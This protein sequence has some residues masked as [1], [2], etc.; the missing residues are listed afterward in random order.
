[1]RRVVFSNSSR[2]VMTGCKRYYY[3]YN[4]LNLRPEVE[5]TNFRVGGVWH[6]IKQRFYEGYRSYDWLYKDGVIKIIPGRETCG[7]EI[8]PRLERISKEVLR[9]KT[10][11][12][13]DSVRELW[14]DKERPLLE[15]MAGTYPSMA[16]RILDEYDIFGVEIP[17]RLKISRYRDRYMV[18][19][20]PLLSDERPAT[21]YVGVMDLGLKK[22]ETNRVFFGENKSTSE[23]SYEAYLP[24]VDSNYQSV[25]YAC[26][27][28]SLCDAMGL[29]D[30]IGGVYIA[31]R[32]KIPTAPH[33]N[34]CTK[35][36]GKGVR[37]LKKEG[38]F[39]CELCDG[40]GK[41]ALSLSKIETT[42]RVIDKVL[43]DAGHLQK[44]HYV[45]FWDDYEK[46]RSRCVSDAWH[47]KFLKVHSHFDMRMWL[48]DTLEVL[49]QY[50]EWERRPKSEK[51]YTRSWDFTKCKKCEFRPVCLNGDSN[52]INQFFK[53][54][55]PSE[56]PFE[57]N[58]RFSKFAEEYFG[59][60]I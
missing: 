17:F 43:K 7:E 52:Y 1:M 25:G 8:E 16:R 33:L 35:C 41:G 42:Q 20:L 55:E 34:Q 51:R 15:S 48:E 50:R 36:K 54:V 19:W 11:T 47:F 56:Y 9:E 38:E 31:S 12:I 57:F 30:P 45:F 60:R 58:E 2:N 24:T 39:I 5:N 10:V 18:T 13:E 22:K 53:R 29:G 32:K 3:F 23:N 59:V 4:I 44:D 40:S 46:W 26:A 49:S 27:V 14:M 37:K 28:S 6:T 21:E